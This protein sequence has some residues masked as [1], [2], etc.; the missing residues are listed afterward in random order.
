[1]YFETFGQF[2]K[3]LAQ[4]RT[5]LDLAKKHGEA[6]KF[7]PNLFLGF[8]LAPDQFAFARQVQLTCDTAKNAAK[9]LTGKDVPAQPDTEQTLDELAT[10]VSSV[11]AIL[12][13]LSAKDFEGAATR[14]VSQPRWEG[15]W[16]PGADYFLQHALPNFYFH[17]SHC[18]ALLRH[19]GVNLGKKDYLGAVD[20]RDPPAP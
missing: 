11:I 6:K 18:Y 3:Q 15:K 12:D 17:V 14:T 13:G 2:K 10:R 4:L 7:D 9:F 8:R 16:M 20:R 5:W 1:M 19:N